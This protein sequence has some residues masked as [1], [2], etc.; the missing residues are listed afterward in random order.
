MGEGSERREVFVP[1]TTPRQKDFSS[2]RGN[3]QNYFRVLFLMPE[4]CGRR[5]EGMLV[6]DKA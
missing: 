1:G 5:G 2:W 3:T 6:D 4:G